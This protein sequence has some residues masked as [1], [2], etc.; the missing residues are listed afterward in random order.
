M[1]KKDK[2]SIIIPI[3]NGEKHLA[4]CLDTIQNQTYTNLEIICI[5]DGSRDKSLSILKEYQKKDDRFIV[6]DQKNAGQSKARNEGIR[7]A[8]GKYISFVDCDDFIELDMI[9]KMVL[10]AEE[11]NA[12]IVITN[13]SLYFEDTGRYE[14]YRD[15][16]LYYTLKNKVFTVEECPE[17]IKYVG[18]WDKLF[19]TDFLK[20]NNLFFWENIIYEDH[21]YSV[22]AELYANRISLIPEHLYYYRKNAGE[23]ITDKEADNDAFKTDFLRIHKKIQEILDENKTSLKVNKAYYEFFMENA[24]MHQRNS[25]TIRF[26]KYFFESMRKILDEKKIK[27]INTINNKMI[28]EYANDIYKNKFFR[29]MKNIH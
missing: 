24:I 5:N 21:L 2:V 20:K 23:S 25:S 11:T 18:V 3:Y 9:E 1:Y 6:I 27:V 17:I 4:E 13:F 7:R 16:V 19:E 8:S 14:S 10:K 29:C 12:D 28:L 26:Y 22:Q 15:E